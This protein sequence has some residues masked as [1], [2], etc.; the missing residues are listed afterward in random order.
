MLVKD[1]APKIFDK[2]DEESAY[3]Q[4]YKQK[5]LKDKLRRV[6]SQTYR[7]LAQDSKT[8]Q[9]DNKSRMENLVGVE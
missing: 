7:N 1:L 3:N 4:K 9:E 8:M 6:K 5:L 2:D